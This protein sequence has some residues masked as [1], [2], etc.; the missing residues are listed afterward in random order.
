MWCGVFWDDRLSAFITVCSVSTESTVDAPVALKLRYFA[1]VSDASKKK[2]ERLTRG[3]LTQRQVKS[4]EDALSP[5]QFNQVNH[6]LT[7]SWQNYSLGPF[8]KGCVQQVLAWCEG[9]TEHKVP[10]SHRQFS[11]LRQMETRDVPY[12]NR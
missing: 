9:D 12:Q 2:K 8:E 7:K 3:G 5:E 1:K 10:L 6:L 4:L 11:L